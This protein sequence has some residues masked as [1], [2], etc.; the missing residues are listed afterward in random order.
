M[1]RIIEGAPGAPN[2]NGA[3]DNKSTGSFFAEKQICREVL[4]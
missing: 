1:A 4:S 3:N 2:R